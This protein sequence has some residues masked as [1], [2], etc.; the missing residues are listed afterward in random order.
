MSIR[1]LRT[2]DALRAETDEEHPMN[3]QGF[4]SYFKTKYRL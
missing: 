4:I 2:Y 1:L 3:A